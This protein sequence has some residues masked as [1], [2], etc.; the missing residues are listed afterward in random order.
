MGKLRASEEVT[1]N[2]HSV[3]LISILLLQV[4]KKWLKQK[5]KIIWLT[6]LKTLSSSTT[7]VSGFNKYHP[8][9]TS[10]LLP[11]LLASSP[12]FL[13]EQNSQQLQPKLLHT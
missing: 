4:G 8:D 13:V 5:R 12:G 9:L 3:Y 11:S 1:C 7:A 10:A 2:S 6:E